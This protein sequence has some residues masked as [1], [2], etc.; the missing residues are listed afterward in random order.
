VGCC[1]H[2]FDKIAL[3]QAAAEAFVFGQDGA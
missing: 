2:F 3:G 1:Q